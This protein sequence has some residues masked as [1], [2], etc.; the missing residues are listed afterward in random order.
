MFLDDVATE[1]LGY[2]FLDDVA[3]ELLGYKT[4]WP[5]TNVL[6]VADLIL[7][8][9]GIHKIALSSW[10]PTKHVTTFSHDF[11]TLLFDVGTGAPVH[12]GQI[13][14]DLIMNHRCGNNMSHK[15]PFPVIIF[16][17]LEGQKPLQ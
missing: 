3:T 12:F 14:F 6:R 5:K 17:L 11:T 2:M 15:L 7:K 9:N 8:Y 10:Y 13:I 16:G 1:L 4:V